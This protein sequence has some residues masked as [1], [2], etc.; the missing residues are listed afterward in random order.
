[1]AGPFPFWSGDIV[2]LHEGPWGA[3]D[4]LRFEGKQGKIILT[5]H[6]A[7]EPIMYLIE[8]I[9]GRHWWRGENGFCKPGHE[10]AM[11][12]SDMLKELAQIVATQGPEAV[13]QIHSGHL[14]VL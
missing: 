7:D 6:N 2:I 3:S 12:A 10:K 8:T 5:S 11:K 14:E 13:V 1:M 9:F 4:D